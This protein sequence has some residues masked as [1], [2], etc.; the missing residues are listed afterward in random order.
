MQPSTVKKM[1]VE[2]L[3]MSMPRESPNVS[4]RTF[5]RTP[6]SSSFVHQT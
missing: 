6:S 4:T 5:A 3:S 2:L 1:D